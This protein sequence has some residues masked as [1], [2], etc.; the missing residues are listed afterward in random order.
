MLKPFALGAMVL[1]LIVYAV[2][3]WA[4]YNPSIRTTRMYWVIGMSAAICGHAIWTVVAQKLDDDAGLFMYALLWDIGFT[5]VSVAVPALLFELR[6][7]TLG[8]VG[9]ALIIAGGLLLKQKGFDEH[10]KVNTSSRQIAA[11]DQVEGVA[12]E[13]LGMGQL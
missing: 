3:I 8:Y 7:S 4:M 10:A 11:T 5:A 12:V 6:V 9:V 13:A 1:A 2:S